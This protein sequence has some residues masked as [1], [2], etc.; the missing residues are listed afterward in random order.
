[1]EYMEKQNVLITGGA[2]GIGYALVE[3]FLNNGAK[4]WFTYNTSEKRAKEIIDIYSQKYPHSIKGYKVDFGHENEAKAI[5]EQM[6]KDMDCID[7]LVNNVGITNDKYFIMMSK[8]EWDNVIKINLNSC[9]ISTKAVLPHMLESDN[10]SIINI[11]SVGGINGNAG[12]TNYA[13][14]K[15]GIIVFTKALA[16]E[17]GGKNIRVNALA[18][19]YIETKMLNK[20]GTAKLNECIKKIPMGRLGTPKEVA[21]VALFL[22]SPLASYITGQTIIVDG[23]LM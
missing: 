18:P 17:L 12:Q 20:L 7:V 3:S 2:S 5:L 4:V 22:A 14:S 16:K 1:M 9:F 15:A 11:S 23:G 13:A 10:A 19:G 6:A 21:N 8:Q